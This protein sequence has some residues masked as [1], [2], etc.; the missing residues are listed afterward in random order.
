MFPILVY[1][2]YG[3]KIREAFEHGAVTFI[4][5]GRVKLEDK[6]VK[7]DPRILRNFIQCNK[8]F[9]QTVSRPSGINR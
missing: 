2:K 6:P 5:K 1:T 4:D 8:G 9:A 3:R 7:F